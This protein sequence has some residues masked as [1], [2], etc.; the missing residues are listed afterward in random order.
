MNL[1]ETIQDKSFQ[2]LAE[3]LRP[4]TLKDF[5]G[6]EKILNSFDKINYRLSANRRRYFVNG[7]LKIFHTLFTQKSNLR[8]G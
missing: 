8:Q 3:K 2:P 1:F 5:V 6:Q 4:Q 7:T